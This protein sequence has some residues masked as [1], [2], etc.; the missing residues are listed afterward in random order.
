MSSLI[1]TKIQD[2]YTGLI[3]TADNAPITATL[4]N[5][6]DG[7]GGVLP[8]QVSTAGVNFTG[9]VTGI[10]AGGLAA[11]TGTDSM[12]S[13][14]TSVPATAPG[15][16]NIALGQGSDTGAVGNDIAITI[17]GGAT[18]GFSNAFGIYTE[19]TGNYSNAFGSLCNASAVNAL[20]VGKQASASA[21]ASIAIGTE[22][23]VASGSDS[24]IAIGNLANVDAGFGGKAIAI[25]YNVKAK[26]DGG[27]NIG[28]D[29]NTTIG[30]LDHF[31]P[32]T[33]GSSSKV[34]G[35]DSIAI[36][37]NVNVNGTGTNHKIAIG[38]DTT[39]SDVEGAVALGYGVT[40]A[41]ANTVTIK[42]L[43]MLDYATLDFADDAAAATGGIPL[44]GVYHT[45]GALKI[46][47]A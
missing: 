24:S 6:E 34:Q 20:A 12:V 18:G 22:P 19:A 16:N 25:G 38:T 31:R 8:I 33:I 11:G 7:N 27:V 10:T 42:K 23:S 35:G 17:D 45:S 37:T 1:N 40:A 15:P 9:T 46:R 2:T 39:V 3:K 13:V 29:L 36:G 32:I 41:T 44:G 30:A 4:K 26:R 47:V 21:A 43:Q 5:L 14:L 28:K